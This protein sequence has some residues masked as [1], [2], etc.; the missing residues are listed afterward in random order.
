[1]IAI[2]GILISALVGILLI[3]YDIA[4]N[5]ATWGDLA[6]AHIP[7]YAGILLVILALGGGLY[8]ALNR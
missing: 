5:T 7:L 8:K 6:N 1:M 4:A 2:I 3:G